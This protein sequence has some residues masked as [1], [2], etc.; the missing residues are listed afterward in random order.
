[1]TKGSASGLRRRRPASTHRPTPARPP[2]AKAVSAR[3][4]QLEDQ[5][6]RKRVGER[7]PRHSSATLTSTLPL[8]E[9]RRTPRA[10]AAQSGTDRSHAAGWLQNG[11]LSRFMASKVTILVNPVANPRTDDCPLMTDFIDAEGFRANVGIVL[12]RDDRQVLLGGRTGGRGWQFRRAACGEN[13]TPEQALYRELQEGDR[14]GARRRRNAGV[15]AELAAL[16]AAAAICPAQYR[17]A[18]HRPEAALVPVAADL[19]E[20]PRALRCDQE[21]V[22]KLALGRLL[23]AGSRGH[24]L[25]ARRL[26]A[27]SMSWRE[28]LSTGSAGVAGVV[29]AGENLRNIANRRKRMAE[30]PRWSGVRTA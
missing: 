4:A 14:F 12:I 24:L 19:L 11:R 23:D 29:G 21:P 5:C 2:A 30:G 28:R 6:V 22:R 1:M 20:E 27:R 17:P 8:I 13:E 16:S 26:R 7:K 3:Q 9:T 10:L 15:D 25:Q 18:L